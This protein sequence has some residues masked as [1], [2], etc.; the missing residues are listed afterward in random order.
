MPAC[1]RGW[2]VSC[3]NIDF[4]IAPKSKRSDVKQ[5]KKGIIIIDLQKNYQNIY[6]DNR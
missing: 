6:L 1:R 5:K 3:V 4:K 2:P